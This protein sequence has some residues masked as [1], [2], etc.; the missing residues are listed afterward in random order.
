LVIVRQF[1]PGAFSTYTATATEILMI[2]DELVRHELPLKAGDLPDGSIGQR[3]AKHRAAQG[4]AEPLGTASLEMPH[5][6]IGGKPLIV[7][8][9]VYAPELRPKFDE[10]LNQTY[11]PKYMPDYFAKK[12]RWESLM[13]PAASAADNASRRL[14]GL[15]ADLPE[16]Q[17]R[18]LKE[19]GGFV[20]AKALPPPPKK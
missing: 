1:P 9:H 5:I 10:W 20:P 13:L 15:P 11:I 3:F 4:W 12:K 14:T 16:E 7:T 19:A 17:Q 2:E 6:V 8:P 18:A